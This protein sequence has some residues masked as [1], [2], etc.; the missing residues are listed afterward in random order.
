[1]ARYILPG[2]IFTSMFSIPQ[3]WL[4][5]QLVCIFLGFITNNYGQRYN[6]VPY[7]TRDGLAGNMVYDMCQDY[8]G[9][10]WF[11]TDNGLSRFD[12]KNFRTYTVKDG[13]PDN[14]VLSLYE[15]K[16]QRLWIGTFNNEL[17]FLKDGKFFRSGRD[18]IFSGVQ[19][20]SR[21]FFFYE[22]DNILW[23][24]CERH[25]YLWPVNEG[26]Q[27]LK[28]EYNLT[29]RIKTVHLRP[30]IAYKPKRLFFGFNDSIFKIVSDG[31]LKFL[32]SEKLKSTTNYIHET[33]GSME[34]KKVL[35]GHDI[36]KYSMKND[37]PHLI[38]TV[39][40]CFEWDQD[41]KQ[42]V[43]SFLIGKGVTNALVD[44]EGIYWFST[45]GDGVY[46]LVS[47]YSKVFAYNEGIDAAN[48][49]FSI[50]M[51]G[52][53]MITGHGG[54]R[55]L[56]WDKR[57]KAKVYSFHYLLE[58]LENSIATNRL[59][60]IKNISGNGLLLGFD[61]YL[62]NWNEK[63]VD[64]LPMGSVK[65]VELIGGDS[66]LVATGS[67]VYQLSQSGFSGIDTIWN[68][69]ATSAI[70]FGGEY[71][72]GTLNGLY[73]IDSTGK[74]AYLGA[75]HP[76]LKRRIAGIKSIGNTLWAATSDSGL[77]ALQKGKVIQTISEKDGLS[78]NICRVLETDGN[79]LW[80]GTNKGVNKIMLSGNK[81]E[82]RIYNSY[83]V[84]PGDAISSIMVKDNIVYVGTPEG[85]TSF[86]ETF[87][88][89]NLFC[90]IQIDGARV[91]KEI[92]P[93]D[94]MAKVTYQDNRIEFL[95][96]GISTQAAGAISFSYKLEGFDRKWQITND[97]TVVYNNLP[98]GKYVF[99]VQARNIFGGSSK[100]AAMAIE[101]V[102][103]FWYSYK[104][105]MFVI[106]GL[107]F[108]LGY[109]IY[110]NAKRKQQKLQ[111]QIELERHMA[112]LEQ[113][114]LQSQMN[115]HFIFNSLNSIQ[116][117]RT[118]Q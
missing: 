117:Y 81:P 58:G 91:G 72:I 99:Y 113:R 115:P 69:R 1:V 31:Q 111:D 97:Q 15:D 92:F 53:T 20:K 23:I 66:I 16:Q 94:Q 47:K 116:Q 110:R 10:L 38:S 46:K 51:T 35:I 93:G 61:S 84:L 44:K 32:F 17:C 39:N 6:Y 90:N 54:S 36:V 43:D 41:K 77:I 68:S 75:L 89:K 101:V 60:V 2:F 108:L 57:G 95:L 83:N 33:S 55:I 107:A 24:V 64:W 12:G 59:K 40:G 19:P 8:K 52:D 112:N 76:S 82:I 100:M 27:E 11:G 62:M 104:F 63:V 65:T 29:D 26:L 4:I 67:A 18:T 96:S 109:F 71:F 50:G 45:L 74:S 37:D 86:E 85:L 3:K 42:K 34:G 28:F 30:I 7:T 88:R 114:A 48:E 5:L 22:E 103:P 102:A 79:H 118:D 9:F 49:V 14:E 78:S 13:L 70:K 106:T 87:F 21:P 25:I 80:V 73:K 56:F 105:W 98:A